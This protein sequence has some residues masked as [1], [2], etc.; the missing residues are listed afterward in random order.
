MVR[1]ELLALRRDISAVL[2][3]L[4]VTLDRSPEEARQLIDQKRRANEPDRLASSENA[5]VESIRGELLELRR[6]LAIVMVNLILEDVRTVGGEARQIVIPALAP[7][8]T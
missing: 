4:Y 8:T 6:D 5:Q 2:V 7:K 1:A 3:N